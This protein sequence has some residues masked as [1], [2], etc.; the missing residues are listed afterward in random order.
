MKFFLAVALMILPAIAQPIPVQTFR[1]QNGLR[2]L[3]LENHQHP[4]IRLQLR[5]AWAP[6]EGLDAS[7]TTETR[8]GDSSPKSTGHMSL[9]PLALRVL[10]QCTVGN[11]SRSAFNRAVEERGLSLNL[12]GTPDGPVWNL[13][14]GSPEA[15]TAFALMA[16]AASRP[17]P[18][19][20][21]L[22]ALKLR[23]IHDLHERG[24]QASARADF[25]RQLER[26]DLVLEPM[27][28]KNLGK[29]F[30]ED[31]Q[32]TIMSSLRPDRAV[33]AISGD[34]NLSQARQLVQL[35][36]GTWNE[37]RGESATSGPK[38]ATGALMR[39]PINMP[40]DNRET[41]LGLPFRASD[42]NQRAA[43]DLLSLWLPRV[44]GTH[45][46]HIHS[47]ATGWRSLIL[48]AETDGSALRQ[49]L[50]ALKH[51][52]LNARDLEQSKM[53]WAAGRRALALH[54]MEQLSFEARE[55]LLG[56]AP[57][58]QEI[59][60]ADLAAFNATLRAWL[61]LDFARVLVFGGIQTTVPKPN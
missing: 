22:D 15:E 25:L 14:G 12:S 30:L 13:W 46:C 54:P 4:L 42:R 7:P 31:L 38:P 3:L 47:G 58:E 23:L 40:S 24:G 11:R 51:S 36:F 1:L 6:V 52:G 10:D 28:E 2:V 59:Q 41:I 37:W 49:E 33:L 57:T 26:P 61:D 53:L 34:L 44:L 48:T 29:I 56:P 50:L 43:Q 27:T 18:E 20:G 35:N 21:D 60:E 16:D 17:I 9:E 55:A 19:G 39:Q 45:R 8:A 32:R 5:V